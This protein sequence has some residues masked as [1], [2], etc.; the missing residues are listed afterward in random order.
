MSNYITALQ[1]VLADS[2]SLYLKTQNY[3]WNIEG[4]HFKPL[5]ELFEEQY[6]DLFEAIDDIAERIRALGEKVDGSYSGF[7]KLTKMSEANKDL[8]D[9][10]MIKDLFASN[11]QLMETM[12]VTLEA[13]QD[14]GDEVTTDLMIGRLTVH[15][16]ASWMLRSSLPASE[17]ASLDAPAKYAA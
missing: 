9:V 10:A 15:E 1:S 12:K 4:P 17:R 16:K 7:S 3:H 14:A 8:D 11:Q 6:R 2:Y 5:H 13:A